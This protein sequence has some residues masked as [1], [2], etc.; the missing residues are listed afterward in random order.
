M[1]SDPDAQA[2]I[3]RGSPEPERFPTTDEWLQWFSSLKSLAKLREAQFVVEDMAVAH[4]A[5]QDPI[6]VARDPLAMTE[7]EERIVQGGLHHGKKQ[8]RAVTTTPWRNVDE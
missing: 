3:R 2:V 5:R 8:R 4:R 1:P 7:I 6:F